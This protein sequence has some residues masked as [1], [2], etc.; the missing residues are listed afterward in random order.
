[1]KTSAL[2][3]RHT[4]TGSSQLPGLKVTGHK[5]T[6]PLDHARPDGE[7]LKIFAR[8][9]VAIEQ[10][11][12]ESLPWL[13]F[14]QGGPGFPSPRPEGRGGW[15]KRAVEE[16]RVLLLDQRGTGLS[17]PV[18]HQTLSAL[19]SPEIQAE[20]LGHFRADSIVKDAELIRKQLMGDRKWTGLGQ[21]F[22]GFCMFTYLSMAPEG[23]EGALVTGGIPPIGES[24]DDVYRATY[25][26]VVQR[27]KEYF[28]RYPYDAD[29]MRRVYKYLADNEVYTAQK[30]RLRPRRMQQLGLNFG[31]SSGFER[32]HYAVEQA[33]VRVGEKEELSYAFLRG[34]D[35]LLDFN[36]NPIYS[37]LHEAI[38]CEGTASG[39]AAERVLS[40]FSE[41]DLN[42]NEVPYFTGEMIYPW[43]FDEYNCLE[44]L[45]RAAQ[46]LADRSDWPD[47]YDLEKL[48]SNSVP[49]VATLYFDDMYVESLYSHGIA[50]QIPHL[51][52]W[53]TNEFEHSGLRD[54]G[55]RILDRML[56]MLKGTI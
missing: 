49:A 44:P 50:K 51:R 28:E 55:E 20:Y 25:M 8:E 5:F 45:K 15:L 48:R 52:L 42:A 40:E 53:V 9:V 12:D 29:I 22:G 4:I 46:I 26:R 38:Y 19:A 16:Y 36:T 41:F 33:F 11:D 23:L 31:F 43:M 32:V 13:V 10:K 3:P 34:A 7:A 37:L 1:M 39:W 24:V 47:L 30:E 54:D 14:F 27:N 56:G 6:V 35:A 2:D 18:T 17:T 21:S